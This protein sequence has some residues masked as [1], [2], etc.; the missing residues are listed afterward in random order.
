MLCIASPK[1]FLSGSFTSLFILENGQ[2]CWNHFY[3]FSINVI[4]IYMFCFGILSRFDFS[5]ATANTTA[6]ESDKGQSI[7]IDL[8]IP[9]FFINFLH[10]SYNHFSNSLT[11]QAKSHEAAKYI[12]LYRKME[13]LQHF[14]NL[15]GNE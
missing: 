8:E 13:L 12:V 3:G 2:I 4:G 1:T 9:W 15:I 7:C 11:I 14:G 10:I 6:K 5:M